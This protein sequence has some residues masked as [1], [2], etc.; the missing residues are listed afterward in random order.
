MLGDSSMA[1]AT[2]HVPSANGRDAV[3]IAAFISGPARVNQQGLS[4]RAHD[5]RRLA[6]FHI[7][8]VNLQRL[9][10]SRRTTWTRRN[11]RQNTQAENGNQDLTH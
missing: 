2:I 3:G 6:A 4:R 7:D 11:H 1:P 8:K 9:G 10:V 5:E